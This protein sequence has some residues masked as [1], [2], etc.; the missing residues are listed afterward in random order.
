MKKFVISITLTLFLAMGGFAQQKFA[1]VIG[2]SNYTNITKLN[3]PVNDANDMDATLRGL[4]FTVEKVL[5]GNLTQ[6]ENGIVNLKKR[7]KDSKGSYGFFFYAGHGVQ[8]NGENYLIPVDANIQSESFLRRQSISVQEMLDELNDAENALNVV[9]LDACRDNPFPWKRSNSRGLQV[10]GNQP[11]DSIIVFATSAGSTAADGTDRNGLFTSHLLNNLKQPGLEVAEVFR[12]TGSDVSR[13]SNRTQI[14]AIYNQFFETAYL[15][16]KPQ[17]S[18]TTATAPTPAAQPSQTTQLQ[19]TTTQSEQIAQT[20][21]QPQPQQTIVRSFDDF[22]RI[23]GGTF[24][25]GSPANELGHSDNEFQHQVTV[26]SFYI[27][28]YEVTQ[29]EYKK[30]MGKNPS[31]FSSFNG[32]NLPVEN[33]SWYDAIEYC[34]KRS[35]KE[36]LTPVYT[37]NKL[38]KDPNNQNS[39]DKVKWI[40]TWNKNANGYRLPTEAEWEYACRAGMNTAFNN[41]NDDYANSTSVSEVAWYINNTNLRTHDVGMK[42]ANAW[43]LYDMH[44]NVWEWCWNWYGDYSSEAQTDPM[45]ASSG[46]FRVSR[47]GGCDSSAEQVRSAY[48]SNNINPNYTNGNLGFRVVRS[49]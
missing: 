26:S 15:G 11:A 49:E 22:I 5:N 43:G 27:G 25:M 42:D 35:Q 20:Q 45:G 23:Q 36:G 10:V 6:M 28:E 34:N 8:S 2:N 1:L 13:A 38:K 47:G 37:I 48:R 12:R 4:G 46:F 17:A 16:N 40:V 41:N 39:N 32:D 24:V 18:A 9:V 3:N 19:Q 21:P 44:G 33:V 29:K 14:P 30:I 31:S 7:L